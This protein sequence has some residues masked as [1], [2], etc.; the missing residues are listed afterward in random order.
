MPNEDDAVKT[1]EEKA[2]EPRGEE[3]ILF[4]EF[5][6][7]MPPGR[8]RLVPDLI[9]RDALSVFDSHALLAVHKPEIKIH[10][11]MKSVRVT[12]SLEMSLSTTST[13]SQEMS[14]IYICTMSVEIAKNLKSLH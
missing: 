14:T 5:L 6:E 3:P 13:S 12:D 11:A 7:S 1:G 2:E 8:E 4:A 9:V 10:C